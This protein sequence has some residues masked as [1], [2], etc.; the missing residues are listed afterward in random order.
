[1]QIKFPETVQKINLLYYSVIVVVLGTPLWWYTTD[2]YRAPLPHTQITA[3]TDYKSSLNI[4]V[5]VCFD[6][7]GETYLLLLKMNNSLCL[8]INRNLNT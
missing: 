2:T 6:P 4:P 8:K 5:A 7:S 3:L 1:M